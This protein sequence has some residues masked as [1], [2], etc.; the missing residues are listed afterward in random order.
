MAEEDLLAV[1]GLVNVLLVSVLIFFATRMVNTNTM[2]SVSCTEF[3]SRVH[4]CIPVLDL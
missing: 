2:T 3:A 4:Q 1:F